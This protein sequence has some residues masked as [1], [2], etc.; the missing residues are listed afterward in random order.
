MESNKS[1]IK[2]LKKALKA[3]EDM[4]KNKDYDFMHIYAKEQIKKIK[5]ELGGIKDEWT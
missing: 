4:L 1:K 5:E 3:Y 2:R